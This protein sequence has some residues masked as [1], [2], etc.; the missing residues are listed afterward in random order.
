MWW[1][2]TLSDPG[3]SS[4]T[5]FED[6]PMISCFVFFYLWPFKLLLNL[7]HLLVE[8]LIAL[9]T[10]SLVRRRFALARF[11]CKCRYVPD[12]IDKTMNWQLHITDRYIWC[13]R[14]RRNK[15]WIK[16]K[17]SRIIYF[18]YYLSLGCHSNY[19]Y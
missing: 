15:Q 9:R 18:Q 1:T 13:Q 2:V 8:N 19:W 10:G 14:K 17:H 4:L 3:L 5:H 12:E 7:M 6:N 16:H 11:Y